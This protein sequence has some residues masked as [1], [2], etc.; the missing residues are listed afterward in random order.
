MRKIIPE[1]FTKFLTA[2]MNKET[3]NSRRIQ[4]SKG[5]V[6]GKQMM[7]IYMVIYC[8][9]S[10]TKCLRKPGRNWDLMSY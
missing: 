1:T 7:I 5:L 4:L 8:K 3:M 9:S 6:L 10:T 2:I